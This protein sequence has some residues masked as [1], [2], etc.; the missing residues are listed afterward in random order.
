MARNSCKDARNQIIANI[1][2][3]TVHNRVS[4]ELGAFG[5]LGAFGFQSKGGGTDEF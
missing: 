4:D 1:A 3:L 2:K 5:A